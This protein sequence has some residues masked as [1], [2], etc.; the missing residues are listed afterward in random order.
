MFVKTHSVE[1]KGP[2]SM[3]EGVPPRFA[4]VLNE[5]SFRAEFNKKF[6]HEVGFVRKEAWVT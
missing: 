1:T 4:A 6:S 2:I 5:D 3:I